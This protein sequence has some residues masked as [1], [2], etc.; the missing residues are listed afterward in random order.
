MLEAV[1]LSTDQPPSISEV[2][3]KGASLIRL[4]QRGFNVP[5]AW[6]LEVDFFSEWNRQVSNCPEWHDVQ[7]AEPDDLSEF[8]GKCDRLKRFAATLT[9]TDDQQDTVRRSIA[10]IPV[11]AVRSSSPDEDLKDSS[12]A[13]LYETYLNV[14][15]ED[16]MSAVQSC[17][18]SCLDARVFI[19]KHKLQI[20]SAE[21]R[22]AVVIQRQIDSDV[23]GVAFSINPLNND[24]DEAVINGTYGLGEALV[25]GEITPDSW[26]VDKVNRGLISFNLG[27]KGGIGAE[28]PCLG[29]D[30]LEILVSTIIRVEEYYQEPVDIEWAFSGDE[31]FLLQARPITTC[32]PLP[33]AM[34]TVPGEPRILYMDESLADGITIS[35]PVSTMTNDY[36]M[37]L[38]Q[39]MLLYLDGGL[40]VNLPPKQNLIAMTD[41]R[42]YANMT[43]MMGWLKVPA[44]AGTKRIIDVTYADILET[45]DLSPYQG[46]K[47]GLGAKVALVPLLCKILWVLRKTFASTISAVCRTAIFLQ[48]Y[49]V[50]LAEFDDFLKEPMPSELNIRDFLLH[51]MLPF[52][53]V[54]QRTTAPAL[55]LYVYRGTGRLNSII[56]SSSDQQVRLA[57]AIKSGSD[58]MVM[59]MGLHVFELSTLLPAASF[60]DL[61]RLRDSI[62]DR[63]VDPE[64]LVS[65]DSFLARFGS[66]GPLE[67]DLLQPKYADDPMVVLRQVAVIV[68]GDQSFDPREHHQRLQENREC[69]FQELMGL[70]PARKQTK[71]AKAYRSI[72]DFEHSREIP[73]DH[74]V[75]IQHHLRKYLLRQAEDWVASGRLE[76]ADDVFDLKVE[77][78]LLAQND[79]SFDL[80]S[81]L[82]GRDPYV[83]RAKRVRHFPHAID[84]RGRILRPETRHEPGQLSGSPVSSGIATGPV[85][86][87]HDP[88]EK[89]VLQGDILVAYTTDPGWT[90][91]FINAAAVLLEVG[92]ELQHGA[93]VAREYGKPCVAGI[94]GVT[95]QLVDGQVVEVNGDSGQVR[96]LD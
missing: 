73:K 10:D 75:S 90:P 31:F 47:V 55:A 67:M 81:V 84:S 5:D 91:L 16:V 96:I 58:D 79:Q 41:V 57:D 82:A 22:I 94:I 95:S 87:M 52:L 25:S 51:Y 35:G 88:F 11:F 39:E 26:T 49:T 40:D 71:L 27:T 83:A 77:E 3:G 44:L 19:Y 29:D 62:A 42:I 53:E 14:T 50:R 65:W 54:T 68:K 46:K 43:N 63:S 93:L 12:F 72:C 21:P 59:A 60:D 9:F 30:Q 20:A 8:T 80:R 13:G 85:K 64:F 38:A 28:T 48:Q 34:M 56:D 24:F 4:R 89:E 74:I 7:N 2:G 32:V 69:A 17:Y 92:G 86:V 76:A 61:G 23:S 18:L 1:S 36:L 78:V 37:Y 6:I 33:S 66:R 70:L 45:C 15:V